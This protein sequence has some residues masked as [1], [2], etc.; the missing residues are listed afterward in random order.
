MCRN[1]LDVVAADVVAANILGTAAALSGSAVPGILGRAGTIS[2]GPS[3][4]KDLAA[5]DAT[6]QPHGISSADAV[7]TV[8]EAYD[9][10]SQAAFIGK[11]VEAELLVVHVGTSICYPRTFA[12]GF[13]MLRCGTLPST[14]PDVS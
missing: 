8:T 9:Q 13:N 4:P 12:Y 7:V 5:H 1:V 3:W 10:M 11:D 6:P 2:A 14:S